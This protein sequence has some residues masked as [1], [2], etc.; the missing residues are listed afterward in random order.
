LF[1][2]EKME[3]ESSIEPLSD[4]EATEVNLFMQKITSIPGHSLCPREA[5]VIRVEVQKLIRK[6]IS[7]HW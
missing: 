1:G 2:G 4:Y 5:L 7:D 6:V 3:S